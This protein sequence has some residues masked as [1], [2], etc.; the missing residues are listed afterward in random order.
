MCPGPTGRGPEAPR[1]RGIQAALAGGVGRGGLAWQARKRP[2]GQGEAAQ[3]GGVG[4]AAQSPRRAWGAAPGAWADTRRING[5]RR[6]SPLTPGDAVDRGWPRPLPPVMYANIAVMRA[7]IHVMF[8]EFE[9]PHND[10]IAVD[11]G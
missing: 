1:P 7:R 2:A 6:P 10:G 4:G 5:A 11:R 3:W 8:I 9:I